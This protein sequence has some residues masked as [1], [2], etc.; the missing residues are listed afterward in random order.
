MNK[1]ITSAVV[2][3]LLV[4]SVLSTLN[5]TACEHEEG[6][7][8]LELTKEVEESPSE[9][10]GCTPGYW[11]NH[12]DDWVN[13]EPSDLLVTVFNIPPSMTDTLFLETYLKH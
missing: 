7:I 13:Y 11:K 10:G 3:M 4:L 9:Y 2:M 8:D 12:L 6:I 5:I 1:K